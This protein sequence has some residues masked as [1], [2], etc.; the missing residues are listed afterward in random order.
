[1]HHD[2][3]QKII[4]DQFYASLKASGVE[5]N[6]IPSGQL[7]AL[8]EALADGFIAG[9]GA[10]EREGDPPPV[11][12]GAANQQLS[13]NNPGGGAP[14]AGN[15]VEVKVW[16]GRP[17]LSIGVRYELTSQRLRIYRGILGNRIDEVELIRVKD[18]NVSQNLGERMLNI[19]DIYIVSADPTSPR[20]VLQNIHDPVAVRELFRKTVM[21]E[22]QRRGLY[23]REDIG[24]ENP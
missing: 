19:G 4:T 14:V 9:L 24:E 7:H 3:L 17:Y 2:E 18:T 15:S 11:V 16:H 22:K 5:V 6:A 10:I 23:Y 8:V 21:E 12:P 1:M 20:L 13:P